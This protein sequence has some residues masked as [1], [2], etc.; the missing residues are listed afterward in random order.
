MKLLFYLMYGR[1]TVVQYGVR[2]DSDTTEQFAEKDCGQCA[3]INTGQKTRSYNSALEPHSLSS[4]CGLAFSGESPALAGISYGL[5]AHLSPSALREV[6][7]D[8]RRSI[9]RCGSSLHGCRTSGPRFNVQTKTIVIEPLT[10]VTQL[11]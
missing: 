2:S 7:H 5:Q 4:T 1:D 8:A 9:T 6:F 11:L 10:P 3:A